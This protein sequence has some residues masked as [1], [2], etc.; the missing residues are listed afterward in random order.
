MRKKKKHP[1]IEASQKTVTDNLTAQKIEMHHGV[2]HPTVLHEE[3]TGSIIPSVT[4]GGEKSWVYKE[5]PQWGSAFYLPEGT[6]TWP[7]YHAET[8][9]AVDLYKKAQEDP[10]QEDPWASIGYALQ[11]GVIQL[12]S[13]TIHVNGVDFSHHVVSISVNLG[14]LTEAFD[15]ATT[16]LK[17]LS[18]TMQDGLVHEDPANKRWSDSDSV[19]RRSCPALFTHK[20]PCP[21]ETCS[22]SVY[23]FVLNSIV[24]H[25][26]DLHQWPRCAADYGTGPVGPNIADWLEEVALRDGVDLTFRDP[27]D[28]EAET[29]R[30]VEADNKVAE[31]AGAQL[32]QLEQDSLS[33]NQDFATLYGK[34]VPNPAGAVPYHATQAISGASVHGS[35]YDE[36]ATYA[37]S[38]NA[39][40]DHVVDVVNESLTTQLGWE[41]ES[42]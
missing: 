9:K 24:M 42:E 20:V 3:M 17:K 14:G 39:A 23:P 40:W 19:L 29:A 10:V 31:I 18:W 38:S 8:A 27:E 28:V 12:S 32:A 5:A 26:N 4:G 41:E 11:G 1:W 21:V 7:G 22:N 25:L 34:T 13:P 15:K 2:Q 30:Q 16:G 33:F 35:W 37:S 36:I 6:E